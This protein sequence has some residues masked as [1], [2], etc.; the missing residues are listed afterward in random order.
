[1]DSRHQ[2]LCYKQIWKPSI[3]STSTSTSSVDCKSSRSPATLLLPALSLPFFR[4]SHTASSKVEFRSPA[5]STHGCLLQIA[6]KVRL[7]SESF[8]QTS[9]FSSY[10]NSLYGFDMSIL[11]AMVKVSVAHYDQ[12]SCLNF[13]QNH[14]LKQV[15]Q[16]RFA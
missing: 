4:M 8:L 10:E 2:G 15:N 5:R 6:K 3:N 9:E 12:F 1:M 13:F 14:K 11:C 16:L 7:R